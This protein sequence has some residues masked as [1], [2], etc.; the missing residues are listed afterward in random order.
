MAKI[1]KHDLTDWCH[2]CG[3]RGDQTAD[4]WYR[5]PTAQ[6]PAEGA[7]DAMHAAGYLAPD[8]AYARVCADCAAAILEAATGAEPGPVIRPPPR[9]RHRRAPAASSIQE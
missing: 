8:T 3:Q 9:A 2:L 7:T 5:S 6:P 4:V 1:Q